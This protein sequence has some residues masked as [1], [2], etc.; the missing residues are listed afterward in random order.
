MSKLAMLGG[1]KAVPP[2]RGPSRWPVVT[3]EDEQAIQRVVA[4]GKFTSASRGEQEVRGLEREWAARVAVGHC[5]AV[6]NGTAALSLA[7]AALD[8]QPGDEVIVPAFGFIACALAPLHLLAVPVFVDV[9]PD[10]F[11]LDPAAIEAAVTPRTRAILA[12]HLHGLPSDMNPILAVAKRHGL[13]VVEDAAQAHGA[14]YGGAVVGSIGHI[15]TFSLNVSKNLPACGEGGLLTTDDDDLFRRALMMRQFGELIPEDGDRSYV[16]HTIGWNHKINAIQAAFARSQL[17]RFDTYLKARDQNVCSFLNLL[18]QLPG[19]VPP[20]T[21]VNRQHVWHILRF[22]VDPLALGLDRV[23]AGPLRAA[24]FRALRAEGVPLSHYQPMPLPAQ[25]VFQ[26][27]REL[28][29]YP[30]RLP[31]ARARSYR[32]ED[33]P[34]AMAVIEDSF[35]LQNAHLPPDAG[36]TLHAYADAFEKVWEHMEVIAA[37]AADMAYQPPWKRVL[38][39]GGPGSGSSLYAGQMQQDGLT[40]RI[41]SE[42]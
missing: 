2:G 27:G 9:E 22:R 14:V 29:G 3:R 20:R 24:L 32:M 41:L 21:P 30:W 26:T 25:E 39:R 12:V 31:G 18:E 8:V 11:T 10:T 6:S 15:G 5:V 19:L 1:T 4:S 42:G 36:P 13:G 16:S 28:S 23:E 37:Y 40:R 34:T 17:A 33:Y 7:L 38:A 35:T